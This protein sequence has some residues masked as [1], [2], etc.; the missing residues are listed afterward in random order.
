MIENL[1]VFRFGQLDDQLEVIIEQIMELQK[2]DL[3][4][5]ILQ[6]SNL[7]RDELLARFRGER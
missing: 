2:E 3:N 7:S 4:R 6:L 5:L 1:L